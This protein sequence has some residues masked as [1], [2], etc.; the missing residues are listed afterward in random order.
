MPIFVLAV[1]LV[2][3]TIVCGLCGALADSRHDSSRPATCSA[4]SF[5]PDAVAATA[6]LKKLR[7]PRR[8]STVLEGESLVMIPAAWWLI[9]LRVAAVVTGS[10]SCARPA[11][12]LSG[13]RSEVFFGWLVALSAGGA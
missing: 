7:M 3:A 4:P 13:C 12:I 2:F 5:P 11:W 1:G 10:F 6:V 8:L 9:S